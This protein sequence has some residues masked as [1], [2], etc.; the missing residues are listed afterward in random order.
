MPFWS[1]A[2]SRHLPRS[3]VD[4][5]QG[6][7]AQKAAEQ[8]RKNAARSC[9][10]RSR[11]SYVPLN[12]SFAG[13]VLQLEMH[14]SASF[15][16]SRLRK[17]ASKASAPSLVL[18]WLSIALICQLSVLQASPVSPLGFTSIFTVVLLASLRLEIKSDKFLSAAK[19]RL[20]GKAWNLERFLPGCNLRDAAGWQPMLRSAAA[21]A[22]TEL[23]LYYGWL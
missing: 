19:G 7:R 8:A 3:W 6:Q 16:S 14:Y 22:I 13:T 1:G 23:A 17:A 18:A 15:I 4:F 12:H 9:V 21:C 20:Y 5:S 11:S 2:F 10:L